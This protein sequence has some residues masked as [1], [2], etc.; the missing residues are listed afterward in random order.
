MH[1]TLSLEQ[2]YAGYY[3]VKTTLDCNPKV[4]LSPSDIEA[5]N[6]SCIWGCSYLAGNHLGELFTTI[7]LLELVFKHFLFFGYMSKYKER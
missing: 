5:F 3:G 7:L 2:E 1:V 4:Y 6:F